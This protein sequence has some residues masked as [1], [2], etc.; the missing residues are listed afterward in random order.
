MNETVR[1]RPA[2]TNMVLVPQTRTIPGEWNYQRKASNT[3]HDPGPIQSDLVMIH[4]GW[5][6]HREASNTKHNPGPVED[7]IEEKEMIPSGQNRQ[8]EASNNQQDPGSV[9][10]ALEE[11]MFLGGWNSQIETNYT[12]YYPDHF[13]AS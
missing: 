2:I 6:S 4:G 3:Q 11:E 9:E 5:N 12:E 13:K 10:G 1:G 8:R 7:A